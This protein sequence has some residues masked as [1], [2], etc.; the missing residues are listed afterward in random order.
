GASPSRLL[1][2][3][4]L[5][6]YELSTSLEFRRVLSRSRSQ[7]PV[8]SPA[9]RL[10]SPLRRRRMGRQLTLATTRSS[11]SLSPT[12]VLAWP[13]TSSLTKIGR[14]S[15]RE[16]VYSSFVPSLSDTYIAK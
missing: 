15:C 14:A 12:L 1:R 3:Q 4:Q 2:C 10:T 9:R 7:T 6:A 16:R 13:R 11:P 8:S 5:T